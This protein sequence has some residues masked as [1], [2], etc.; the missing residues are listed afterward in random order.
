M[1][2]RDHFADLRNY[3]HELVELP[4]DARADRLEALK[5]TDPKLAHDL[6]DLL[7]STDFRDLQAPVATRID[8]C[9]PYRVDAK[10]G[11]GGMGEVFVGERVEGGFS[12]RVALKILKALPQGPMLHQRFLR[13][14]QILARLQHPRIARLLDGGMTESGRPWLAME[15]VEGQDLLS[16]CRQRRPNLRQR[17]ELLIQI[18]EAVAFAHSQLVVHRDLK[19][20]NIH[21]DTDNQAHLLDFGVAK[22]LDDPVQD[23][24]SRFGLPMTPRYAAPEQ[25]LGEAVGTSADIHALGVLGFELCSGQMPYL[26]PPTEDHSWASRVLEPNRLDLRSVLGVASGL[27][28]RDQQRARRVLPDILSKAMA[29]EPSRRHPS[30]AALAD[31]LRDWLAQ[32]APRSGAG[33]RQE[34]LQLL[35][36][37]YRWPML[38]GAT[39]FALILTALIVALWQAE[40]ARQQSLRA[41]RQTEA[42]LEVL[43]AASPQ[44]YAGRDPPASEFLIDAANRIQADPHQDAA[45]IVRALS[46]IGN[47]LLNLGRPG[48]AW[49][50]LE[51]AWQRAGDDAGI[52][53]DR[54]LDLL[55]LQALAIDPEQAT[56]LEQARAIQM[57]LQTWVPRSGTAGLGLSAEAALGAVYADLEDRERALQLFANA[58]P[59]RIPASLPAAQAENSLRQ[60]GRGLLKL[61][62]PCLA[63]ESFAASLRVIATA[64]QE[65]SPMRIAEAHWWL[66]EAELDCGQ[67]ASAR[68]ELDQASPALLQ[69][70]GPGH[71]ERLRLSVHMALLDYLQADRDATPATW[72]SLQ[73]DLLVLPAASTL[74]KQTQFDLQR[75]RWLHERSLQDCTQAL[76]AMPTAHSNRQALQR[77]QLSDWLQQRCAN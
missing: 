45:S 73:E 19:P 44:D 50:V 39:T 3:F 42:L 58:A 38:I 57:R 33:S 48:A 52:S 60:R 53:A 24:L 27:N 11:A 47:G 64:R 7:G 61:G 4:D 77:Q 12:Q 16:W 10:L 36:Q 28:E 6:L 43:A 55:K 34:R 65:F 5:S 46:E 9:G 40:E 72:T 71:V 70:Y 2:A 63:A 32:R 37:R 62:E 15:L 22:L 56:A 8:R 35:L 59:D 41:D 66:A 68:A 51:Q 76:P 29:R 23:S 54:R 69:E 25:I 67:F 13:E 30:A 31:D 75:L 1:T 14:R 74:S 26:P 20:G 17:I 21:I 49:T 18:T